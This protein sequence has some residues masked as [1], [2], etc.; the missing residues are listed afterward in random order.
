MLCW[1]RGLCVLAV[2]FCGAVSTHA[3]T[4]KIYVFGNS[5]IHHASDTEATAVPHWLAY[6]AKEGGRDFELDGQFGFLQ[7]FANDLP[8]D[9]QWG[10]KSVKSA[11][12]RK[13]RTFDQV[14]YDT[15]MFNPANFV[16]YQPA[17]HPYDGDNADRLSPV[18]AAE[19][20]MQTVAD[21]KRFVI[22]EGWSDLALITSR[23]PPRARHL[24][25]YH[26][27]NKDEYHDWYVDFAEKLAKRSGATDVVLL[28]VAKILAR[29]FSETEMRN[30]KATDLYL[31]DA[32]HGT[33]TLYFLAGA[34]SYAG[35][36][37]E[38][39]QVGNPPPDVHPIAIKYFADFVALIQQELAF[40]VSD[41][42]SREVEDKQSTASVKTIPATRPGTVLE[43]G[44]TPALAI[45]LDGISD[46][47]TQLPFVNLMKSSRQ[48]T[49]HL[50]GQWGGWG[51]DE[52]QAGGYLDAHGWPKTIP[53][54]LDKIEAILL[55][56]FP[57]A[58]T[59]LDAKYRLTY[60]GEGQVELSGD[61]R[62]IRYDENEIWFR[63][64]PGE[65]SIAIAV[66]DSD[67]AGTGDYIR[68]IAV[69]R[70]DQVTLF[71]AGVVF[72][73]DW[74]A[75]INDVRI[76]RFMDWMFTNGSPIQSWDARPQV[77]DYSYAWRG[78]P[79]EHMLAL[80]NQIGADPWFNMPH[81]ADDA[82]VRA[83]AE[84][85]K[86]GLRPGLVAHAEY[87]N[88]MW[89]FLFP[90][91]HWAVQQAKER[92]GSAVDDGA[93]IQF[94]GMRAAEV[95]AIW[96]SVFGEEA[97]AR[98]KRVVATHTDWPGL[99]H[100]LLQ[101]PLAVEEGMAPPVTQFD[102]YAVT[103]Y[104]GHEMGTDDVAP[105]ILKWIKKGQNNGRGYELAVQNSIALL[106]RG[107]LRE[108][109]SE[110]WPHQAEVAQKYDLELLMY[111][112]GTHVVGV[113]DWPADEEL[114][115]FFNHLNYTP[116]MAELY[117]ELLSAWTALGGT[118]FNAF[119]DVAK[120]SQ[121]GS[122]GALRH[123]QDKNPRHDALMAYNARGATWQDA[124]LPSDFA[125]GVLTRGTEGADKLMGT[126]YAD[127]L[128]GNEGDD[129]LLALG[130][131]DH[132]HGGDGLDHAILPGLVEEYAFFREGNR[133]R[134]QSVHGNIRLYG[135]ETISF[136]TVPGF[137]LAVS[138]F[139]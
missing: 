128:L 43:E 94:A 79:L 102:A 124:R 119:V 120:P 62:P 26:A 49:G 45:G 73:P 60:E 7:N 88:E 87:S 123:L 66:R 113:E 25:T 57:E 23:F 10:F 30:M 90:Q 1:I 29:A 85:V 118:T 42:T 107:S 28:P 36:F 134:A 2:W 64:Q 106:R 56:D 14:G 51:H 100:G 75:R 46:W 82:Y 84:Q 80:A 133:L 69:V 137:V 22:Y 103:G 16:Q 121:W 44:V 115:A 139:F 76:V 40:D 18:T 91:T 138:D 4:R 129:E 112:G 67:P 72:N 11:W 99:E 48:W 127:I 21:G 101:A 19:K 117:Q 20:L 38:L 39:P 31:D 86:E 9:P 13:Y 54:E 92:W 89:N 125:H 96:H 70:E 8:P 34:I 50:H 58:V 122:W 77:D 61:A 126:Q 135:V 98:L 3:E 41:A 83:F 136:S 6:F 37:G 65:G 53:A 27:Y 47:S 32:P 74:I 15:I 104:F 132:L 81:L 59:Q 93:W 5:L 114:T 111:E 105:R 110:A 35:L 71:E 33:P 78:A 95:L 55:T 130:G 97:D 63:F 116:E 108:L 131:D 109:L 17:D 12:T 68:N 24:R 52:L